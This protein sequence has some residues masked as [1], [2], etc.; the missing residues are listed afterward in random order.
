MFIKYYIYVHNKISHLYY[1]RNV[2]RSNCCFMENQWLY[3]ARVR[4]CISVYIFD[5]RQEVGA[6]SLCNALNCAII[7]VD[8]TSSESYWISYRRA[9]RFL[10]STNN[11]LFPSKRL[12]QGKYFRHRV[13]YHVGP[14]NSPFFS[15]C[16]RRA[17][18]LIRRFRAYFF[19]ALQVSYELNVP[20]GSRAGQWAPLLPF[21]NFSSNASS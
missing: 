14:F 15:D 18:P 10:A 13:K 20:R 21:T 12:M 16:T 3:T 19:G 9:S 17:H 1:T 7:T 2:S 11:A 5:R 8:T 4:D 6:S